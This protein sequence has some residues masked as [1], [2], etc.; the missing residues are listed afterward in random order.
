MVEGIQHPKIVDNAIDKAVSS[1]IAESK[2]LVTDTPVT[3]VNEHS[4][5]VSP[6]RAQESPPLAAEEFLDATAPRGRRI[7]RNRQ[8]SLSFSGY[9]GE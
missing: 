1:S 6:A 9:R 5:Q 8:I 4:R 7:M 3:A 2:S